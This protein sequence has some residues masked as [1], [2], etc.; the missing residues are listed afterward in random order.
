MPYWQKCISHVRCT[1]TNLY[2]PIM[3]EEEQGVRNKHNLHLLFRLTH[4]QK[5]TVGFKPLHVIKRKHTANRTD[6]GVLRHE[7]DAFLYLRCM[8]PWSLGNLQSRIRVNESS[9]S[10][11][12][13]LFCF[14]VRRV[15][16]KTKSCIISFPW[17][18]SSLKQYWLLEE[19]I[20]R[21]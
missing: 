13:I 1:C 14:S 20:Y 3:N 19:K 5:A 16:L 15:S 10:T 18:Y 4:L 7:A 11:R 2:A 12:L 9:S 21:K 17:F 8:K 6:G